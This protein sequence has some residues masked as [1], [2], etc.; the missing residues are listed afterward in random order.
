MN[1]TA[2]EQKIIQNIRVLAV[3]EITNVSSGH[4][5]F[6]NPKKE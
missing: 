3:E 1:N 4:P 5:I 2:L 6:K